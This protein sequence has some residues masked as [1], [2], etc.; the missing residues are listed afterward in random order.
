MQATLQSSAAGTQLGHVTD[1]KVDVQSQ[2]RHDCL[3]AASLMQLWLYGSCNMRWV[4]ILQC[5]S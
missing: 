3:V 2:G 5:H 1:H 4:I